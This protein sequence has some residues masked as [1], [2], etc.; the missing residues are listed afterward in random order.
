MADTYVDNMKL[1]HATQFTDRVQFALCRYI[2][3]TV[4][5]EA[6]SAQFHS[7]RM[8]LGDR[9]MTD[10]GAY[11]GKLA[12]GMVSDPALKGTYVAGPPTDSSASDAAIDG[13]VDA[14]FN[15]WFNVL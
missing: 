13:V 14:Q 5:A 1:A 11:A 15:K 8:A 6:S 10:P 3:N 2:V 9:I 7:E 4:R 12:I